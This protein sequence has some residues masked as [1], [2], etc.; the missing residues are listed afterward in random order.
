MSD[1]TPFDAPLPATAAPVYITP[2]TAPAPSNGLGVSA[3]VLGIVGVV[4]AWVPF[5]GFILG[6]LATVFGAVGL[7]YA[8]KGKATNKGMAIAGLVLGIIA[9]VFWPLV[10][11]TIVASVP[12]VTP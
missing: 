6:V 1:A 10:L 12:P 7:S 8:R 9:I 5:L 3:L 2:A 4:L 11:G